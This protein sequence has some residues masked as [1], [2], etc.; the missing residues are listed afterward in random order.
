MPD[1]RFCKIEIIDYLCDY[2]PI[3]FMK[4]NVAICALLLCAGVLVRAE[5]SMCMVLT[6]VSG[7]TE[8]VE[9]SDGMTV[10][11]D[12]DGMVVST[13]DNELTYSIDDVRSF[14]YVKDESSSLDKVPVTNA[15]LLSLGR[16]EIVIRGCGAD[17]VATICNAAGH[18]VFYS[19]FSAD[20][21][22]EIGAM[23]PGVYILGLQ[24]G[25]KLKFVIR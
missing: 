3:L 22:I 14:V 13:P 10:A 4:G 5:S 7:E 6:L 1:S 17:D 20:L 18:V 12:S 21:R 23:S 11:V 2:K 16:S 8:R 9:V 25:T 15:P 19:P 24:S